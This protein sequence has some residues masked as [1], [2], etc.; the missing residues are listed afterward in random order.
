MSKKGETSSLPEQAFLSHSRSSL[1]PYSHS[2]GSKLS[3]LRVSFLHLISRWWH[4]SSWSHVKA[5]LSAPVST[6]IICVVIAYALTIAT[7]PTACSCPW[8]PFCPQP[9]SMRMVWPGPR[10][11]FVAARRM[12]NPFLEILFWASAGE[13][14]CSHLSGLPF[15]D[16]SCL[17]IKR[18]GYEGLRVTSF[19]DTFWLNS[20]PDSTRVDRVHPI[21]PSVF[22]QQIS[23]ISNQDSIVLKDMLLGGRILCSQILLGTAQP[24]DQKYHLITMQ[25]TDHI[26]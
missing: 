11:G 14:A 22:R 3:F 9:L 23:C 4:E 10:G 7:A 1:V 20:S 24:C 26:S 16:C 12:L 15:S 5:F 25:H 19:L 2:L 6:A 18:A 8:K 13:A 21:H 17:P